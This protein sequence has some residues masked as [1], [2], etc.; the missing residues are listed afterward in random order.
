MGHESPLLCVFANKCC[1]ALTSALTVAGAGCHTTFSLIAKW[2]RNLFAWPQSV[3]TCRDEPGASWLIFASI[4]K[5]IDVS[6]RDPD[7]KI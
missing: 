4:D 3:L 5:I 2:P 6:N 1:H 7:P